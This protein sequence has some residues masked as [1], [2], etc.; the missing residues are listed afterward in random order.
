MSFAARLSAARQALGSAPLWPLTGQVCD[1]RGPVVRARFAGGSIG[2]ACLIEHEDGNEISAEIIGLEGP[3]AL[4]CP[5]GDTQGVREGA[6][7]RPWGRALSVQAGPALLGRIV[8]PFGLP[9]DGLG[10]LQGEMRDVAIRKP[11]PGPMQRPLIDQVVPTGIRAIDGLCTLGRGQRIALFGPP[12][13]G[14]STLLA[15]IARGVAA[16][17]VVVGLVGERG[18]EVRE[19]TERELP[20]E[21]RSRVICV[22]ATSD[23]PAVDR[24]LCAQTAT[25]IAEDLRDRGMSVLLMIDSLTRAARALREVGLAAGEVPTRRGYPA[26]VYPALPAL[27][28]RAGRTD[29]GD[30]TGIYTVLVEDDGE[31]DP[32]AEEVRSLTDGHLTLSRKLA[33]AGHWPAIDVLDS[34]S[35]LM[36]ALA[37]RDHIAA[38]QRARQHLSKYREI[39]LLL[40]VGQFA[41]GADR[42]ADAAVRA[43]PLLDRFLKQATSDRTSWARVVAD[44]K[45]VVA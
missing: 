4:L 25:A 28:E 5:F 41:A 1:V 3:F 21:A 31:G 8:D 23:R 16:D 11:A 40:Q 7:V 26:S 24:V 34:L 13:T 20:P 44:L 27:I 18:R 43:K 17:A 19:F 39:E 2:Q 14:K 9:V 42:A 33:E 12:G 35:R 10:P 36:Q 45:R 30:I 22:V 32:I 15:A 38:A 6:V 37:T 29:T